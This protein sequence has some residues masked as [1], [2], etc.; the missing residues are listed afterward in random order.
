[1]AE[2]PTAERPKPQDLRDKRD[3]GEK[4]AP[5]QQAIPSVPAST[6]TYTQAVASGFWGTRTDPIGDAYY[7]VA[8]AAG[9]APKINSITPSSGTRSGG[10]TI[11]VAGSGLTGAGAVHVGQTPCTAPTVGSDTSMTGVTP[12]GQGKRQPVTVAGATGYATRQAAFDY[13]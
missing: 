1:M 3:R 10:T 12:A 8:M 4:D 6:T 7:T 9:P 11:T 5:E 2:K 13:T